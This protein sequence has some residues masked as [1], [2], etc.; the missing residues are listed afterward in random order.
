METKKESDD[1]APKDRRCK[2]C[3]KGLPTD[4]DSSVSPF[5]SER[6][7]LNDLSKWFGEQYRI[8]SQSS[9]R[10]APETDEEHGLE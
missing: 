10:S 8:A 2:V 9:P 5:C 6:C 4:T 1:N 7:K 3:G